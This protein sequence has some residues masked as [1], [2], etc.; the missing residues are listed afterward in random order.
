MVLMGPAMDTHRGF[1]VASFE[2]SKLIPILLKKYNSF[3]ILSQ[4]L[5]SISEK[6]ILIFIFAQI[7]HY[8][9]LDV[10]RFFFHK[11]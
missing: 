7:S 11:R 5:L 3:C 8:H 1:V 9:Y 6:Y 2:I 10:D 4:T